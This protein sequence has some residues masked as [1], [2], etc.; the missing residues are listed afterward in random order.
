MLNTLGI[1][2]VSA[3]TNH[4]A[5]CFRRK[6]GGKSLLEWVVRR[7]TDCQQLDGVIVAIGDDPSQQSIR[8]LAPPD[9]PV[10]VGS[11]NDVLKRFADAVDEYPAKSV[12]RIRVDTP[13]VDPELI[14][15]L[16]IAAHAREQCDCIS[17]CL[18]DGRPAILSPVGLFAEW[19]TAK[20]LRKA[21]RRAVDPLDRQD[22]TRF[23][24]AHP[25]SFHLRMIRVPK[26]LDRDDLRL[27]VDLEEDWDNTQDIV[28]A[29][30]SY[31][32]DPDKAG[33]ETADWQRIAG[34]LS[35]QP[36]MRKRMAVLNR[37]VSEK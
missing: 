22:V 26:P 5:S 28:E 19:F 35:Q 18:S 34:L 37:A 21:D 20:A 10:F 9:V 4:I 6:L 16:V 14:D 23:I 32:F 13:F 17:Y 11:Q 24:Y 15:R 29:L 31:S 27:R 12:V 30:D 25:E 1:V 33:A 7:A 3:E 8:Q 2:Q 36:A